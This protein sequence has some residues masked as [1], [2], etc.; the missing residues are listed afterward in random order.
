MKY[1]ALLLFIIV[2]PNINALEHD[3]LAVLTQNHQ[4]DSFAMELNLVQA[5]IRHFGRDYQAE[6]IA[7]VRTSL[8]RMGCH[9]EAMNFGQGAQGRSRHRCHKLVEGR[10][11]SRTCYIESNLGAFIVTY[12]FLDNAHVIYKRWD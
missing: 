10:E 6:A 8:Q 1:M 7:V 9:R 2:S 11:L 3:C 4:R 12:D 5:G